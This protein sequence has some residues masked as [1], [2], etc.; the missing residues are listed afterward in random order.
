MTEATETKLNWIEDSVKNADVIAAH[1]R[2]MFLHRVAILGV[3]AVKD[4][5]NGEENRSETQNIEWGRIHS[6]GAVR[7]W[8]PVG[9]QS[10]PI[11]LGDTDENEL[12]LSYEFTTLNINGIIE[13]KTKRSIKGTKKTEE[14]MGETYTITR[15]LGNRASDPV[16]LITDPRKQPVYIDRNY[17]CRN[18]IPSIMWSPEDQINDYENRTQQIVVFMKQLS[19]LAL[20]AGADYG[21]IRNLEAN[22]VSQQLKRIAVIPNQNMRYS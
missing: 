2:T 7:Q 19:V 15:Q 4:Y 3:T 22:H 1:E 9:W 6:L 12:G 18:Q 11:Y 8:T 10:D 21:T 14:L 20:A 13:T 17:T 16:E 5:L